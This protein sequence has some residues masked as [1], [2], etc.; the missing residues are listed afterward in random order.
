MPK[1]FT[2]WL[3]ADGGRE[4]LSA[5]RLKNAIEANPNLF[6]LGAVLTDSPYY[7]VFSA[8]G[9]EF[10][11]LADALH[12][13]H[14]AYPFKNLVF[15]YGSRPDAKR[16]AFLSGALCHIASDSVL[17]PLVYYFTG[18]SEHDDAET[19]RIASGLHRKLETLIDIASCCG[20][21][22]KEPQSLFE[23]TRK[24]EMPMREFEAF[25][26]RFYGASAVEYHADARFALNCHAG[27]S[28]IARQRPFYYIMTLANLACVKRF[29]QI[30]ALFY[31]RLKL[32]STDFF[33][34]E[35]EYKNPRNGDLRRETI[36]SAIYRAQKL[37]AKLL[38][39]A[40]T[41]VDCGDDALLDAA[42]EETLSV[43]IFL[44]TDKLKYFARPEEREEIAEIFD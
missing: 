23:L 39:R 8:R 14:F 20:D 17:H 16:L 35:L 29:E 30:R 26:A 11:K 10:K 13:E 43:G 15:R 12:G 18:H 24:N 31:P 1:E 32:K 41:L 42:G 22:G 19:A 6:H 21:D 4:K 40:Q 2:H 27:I 28:G 9:R 33:T 5:G 44:K 34:R 36:P 38:D 3:I 7:S 37:C 25:L